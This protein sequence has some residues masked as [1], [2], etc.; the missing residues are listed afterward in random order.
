MSKKAF[1]ITITIVAVAILLEILSGYFMGKAAEK[2][3]DACYE[4]TN[5]HISWQ[6]TFYPGTWNSAE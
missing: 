2:M 4:M 1:A 3:W 6:Q 5:T